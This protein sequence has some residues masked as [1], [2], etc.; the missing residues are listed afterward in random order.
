M[1]LIVKLLDGEEVTLNNVD[2]VVDSDQDLL[3][4]LKYLREELETIEAYMETIFPYLPETEALSAGF[5]G[6]ATDK[7]ATLV[8][9][10]K[11]MVLTGLTNN[12]EISK[13]LGF[14]VTQVGHYLKG[15]RKIARGK[16]SNKI[17]AY[18]KEHGGE[19]K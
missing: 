5:M 9:L 7:L 18:I 11:A 16:P 2:Y 4:E 1:K 14:G 15:T 19:T 3:K 8:D 6:M 13:E 17:F 12:R 10:K